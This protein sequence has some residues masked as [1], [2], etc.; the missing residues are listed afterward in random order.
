MGR[1]LGRPKAGET[2]LTRERILTIALR[3]V[4]EHGIDALSMRRLASELGVDP[5]A[6]YHHLPGKR[7]VLI[8]V[9]E[10]VFGELQ[11]PPVEGDTW[12]NQVRAF[13][14]AYRDLVRA[15]PHLVL[16][17]VSNLEVGANAVLAASE[18]LY[19]ALTAA[20]LAPRMIVRAADLV[21]DYLHGFALAEGLSHLG[22]AGAQQGLEALLDRH[23]LEQFPAMRRA[24]SSLADDDPPNGFERELDIILAGI[25][26]V[27]REA[28]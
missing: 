10:L 17:L 14:R 19:V 28:R 24:L 23:P 20:G 1:K 2:S 26:A 25:E 8:G 15:H 16:Y 5:M 11:V 18:L 13:A 12:Q 6:I 3:L 9:I 7:A 22:Q 4:D 27:V 21:V